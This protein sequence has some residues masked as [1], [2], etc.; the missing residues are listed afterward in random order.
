MDADAL[1]APTHE[2]LSQNSAL[3][4]G[5]KEAIVRDAAAATSANPDRRFSS[6]LSL[7]TRY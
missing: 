6:P 4:S 3:L 5:E 7:L 1:A 2:Q